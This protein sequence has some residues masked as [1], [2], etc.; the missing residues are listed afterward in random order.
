MVQRW[1]SAALLNA[2]RRFRRVRGLQ[3]MPPLNSWLQ[4]P[5][6][7]CFHG[8]RLVQMGNVTPDDANGLQS[9]DDLVVSAACPDELQPSLTLAIAVRRS[10]NLVVSNELSRN[11]IRQYVRAV[12]DLPPDRSES[13]LGLVVA[14]PQRHAEQLK[15]LADLAAMQMDASG[16]FDLVRTPGKFDAAVQ[17][18]LDHLRKLVARALNELGV[19]GGQHRTG[20]QSHMA[21][22]VEAHRAHATARVAR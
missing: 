18:R 14:G 9:V 3:G 1:V 7:F 13:R 15:K 5:I 21:I 8:D 12:I 2:E 17:G 20:R 6:W 11:L 10:P 4:E 22:S 19:V 16:F